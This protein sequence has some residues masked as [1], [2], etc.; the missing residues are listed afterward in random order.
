MPIKYTN[1]KVSQTKKK[2]ATKQTLE[3]KTQ[4][5]NPQ[6]KIICYRWKHQGDDNDFSNS[7]L[8]QTTRIDVSSQIINCSFSKTMGQPTGTFKFILSN[9][10]GIEKGDWKDIL[11][12]GMWCII[13]MS[14]EGDLRINPKVGIPKISQTQ[15]KIRCIGFIDRVSIQSEINEK[16][17]F[18]IV[19]E[20]TGRDFGVIY[21]DTM[22][23]HNI[24]LHE[25]LILDN[26]TSS[27][28]N[29]MADTTIDKA[30]DVIHDLFFYPAK[31]EKVQ[32][33]K[34]G[35]LLD[36]ALQWLLPSSL[37]D[38]IGF[39]FLF[40]NFWGAIPGIKKFSPTLSTL[41]VTRPTDFLSGN[42]WSQLKNISVPELHE[43]FTETTDEG[44]PQ[45][46]FRPIPFS[47]DKSKYPTVGEA[48]TLYKDLKPLV[49]IPTLDVIT[50][51]MG[52]DNHNRYNSFLLTVDTSLINIE[53]N[54]SFLEGSGFPKNIQN[55]IKR[56]GFRPMHVT[57]HALVKNAE[58]GDGRGNDILIREFNHML[59]D[60]WRPSVFSESGSVR[61]IGNN[62]IK[63]GKPLEFAEDTPYLAGKRYY[64]EGYVDNFEVKPNGST[65][66][67][68]SVYLTRGFDI[69]DLE[70]LTFSDKR[71]DQFLRAGDFSPAG[72][73]T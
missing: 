70:K 68:T 53:D 51:S 5:L 57:A 30:L 56:Y 46:V 18:D 8:A 48:I 34:D 19:Y 47:I 72:G 15:M 27:T 69:I 40:A 44:K 39:S 28:L 73:V 62:K 64:I 42:A 61:I 10:P 33:K 58:R 7:Q 59:E 17:A 38:D 31:F 1:E 41:S 6:C 55:S 71:K 22:I 4:T 50:F 35:S 60:Y 25:Q 67:E 23:W 12:R 49:K 26:I 24:F 43:L 66:W 54:I 13:Y 16:G 2:E 63:I 9:S 29:I 11:K 32:L 52:E 65:T 3:Y 14:Q 45:L 20:I 21:S 36:I 37:L